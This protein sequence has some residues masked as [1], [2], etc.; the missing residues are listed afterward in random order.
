MNIDYE[1]YPIFGVEEEYKADPTGSTDPESVYGM[2]A[3]PGE[4]EASPL[5]NNRL[6]TF[7]VNNYNGIGVVVPVS[8]T[9]IGDEGDFVNK[10]VITVITY[11]PTDPERNITHKKTLV[12]HE[13]YKSV[14][15]SESKTYKIHVNFRLLLTAE[16]ETVLNMG[17]YTAGGRSYVRSIHVNVAGDTLCR[18]HLYRVKSNQFLDINKNEL[19]EEQRRMIPGTNEYRQHMIRSF[20]R[21]MFSNVRNYEERLRDCRSDRELFT[22]LAGFHRMYVPGVYYPKDLDGG[23]HYGVRLNYIVIINQAGLDW[24]ENMPDNAPYSDLVYGLAPDDPNYENR[25][26]DLSI[27]K[28]LIDPDGPSGP[29]E[30]PSGSNV[31]DTYYTFISREF[32]K[33]YDDPSQPELG[34]MD[35]FT[36]IRNAVKA[37]ANAKT[38]DGKPISVIRNADGFF[39]QKHY[40]EELGVSVKY[41]TDEWGNLILDENNEPI[42]D[43]LSRGNRI[44][45]YT[46]SDTDTIVAIP[47]AKY[48][49]L[50]IHDTEWI[51]INK[52]D[53]GEKREIKM[54]STAEPFIN[55]DIKKALDPGYYDVIFRYKVGNEPHEVRL[56]SAFVKKA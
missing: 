29:E 39:P 55:K 22:E 28:I 31:K 41:L 3:L 2:M 50:T 47:E 40:L 5:V 12:K 11:S 10:E 48:N 24:L 21:Y 30:D 13:L 46:I 4:N 42:Y 32:V 23:D 52:S 27:R 35:Q 9:M 15:D 17:F 49:G 19:D 8:C 33:P 16:G 53:V 6:K 25:K 7:M 45:D 37:A 36:S 14:Y 26:F 34:I 1:D 44:E 18:I 54:I 56:N 51:F 20:N 38:Y 43:G